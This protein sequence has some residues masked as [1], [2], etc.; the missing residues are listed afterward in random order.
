MKN[1]KIVVIALLG[2]IGLISS[3]PF[4]IN[5]VYI[6][7]VPNYSTPFE[8]REGRHILEIDVS[9]KCPY[10]IGVLFSSD[11]G[12]QPVKN[13]F[14]NARK[15]YLPALIDISLF[16]SSQQ[17]IFSVKDFGGTTSWYRYG[18]NPLRL[19]AGESYFQQEKYTVVIDVKRIE[20]DFSKF[21]AEFFVL[22]EPKGTCGR[23]SFF[24]FLGVIKTKL[25]QNNIT[26]S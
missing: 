6:I 3:T 18:P 20:K 19:I 22:A 13:F 1:I 10:E 5:A 4:L 24:E 15:I 8:F 21:K 16:S 14:G 11:E 7:S 17:K 9:P 23:S 12:H 26:N 2:L 25:M